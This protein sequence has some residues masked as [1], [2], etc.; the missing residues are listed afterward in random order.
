MPYSIYS[1]FDEIV[2][3]LKVQHIIAVVKD[4][5]QMLIKF[6]HEHDLTKNIFYAELR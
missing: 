5:N 3:T 2:Q 6:Y 1:V 4:Y